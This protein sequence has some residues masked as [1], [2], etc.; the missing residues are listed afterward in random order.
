MDWKEIWIY[1][2]GTTKWLG[3]DLGFWISLA[4]VCIIVVIMNLGFWLVKP[5]KNRND[6]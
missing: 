2:F 5:K 4:F 6:L 3:I 1:I